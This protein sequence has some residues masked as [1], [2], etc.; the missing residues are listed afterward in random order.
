MHL[1][2]LVTRLETLDML[3]E[4]PEARLERLVTRLDTREA[5]RIS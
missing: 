2:R 4:S 3:L 1:E 5:S